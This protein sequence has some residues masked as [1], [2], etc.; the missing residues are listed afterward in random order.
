M[1]WLDEWKEERLRKHQLEEES[2]EL[3]EW[4]IREYFIVPEYK[5]EEEFK[6]I[7]SEKQKK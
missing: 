5:E 2:L 7:A 6:K 4:M 3:Y 1:K